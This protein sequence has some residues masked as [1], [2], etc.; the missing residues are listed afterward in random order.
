MTPPTTKHPSPTTHKHAIRKLSDGIPVLPALRQPALKNERE[1]W[2]GAGEEGEGGKRAE[3]FL[4]K[5][6]R[7]IS[8]HEKKEPRLSQLSVFGCDETREKE[9]VKT[10][11]R[12]QGKS[13]SLER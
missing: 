7:L 2:A 4:L 10:L 11:S 9:E 3:G 5:E 1:R 12:G 13:Q 8:H 6:Y